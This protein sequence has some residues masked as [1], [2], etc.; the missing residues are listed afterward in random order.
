LN[1]EAQLAAVLAHEIGHVLSLHRERTLQAARRLAELEA[2]MA[3]RL[4][5]QQARETLGTLSVARVRGYSRQHEIEADTWSEKLL[6]GAGYDAA[7]GAEVL[8][9]FVQQEGFW[10]RVGFELWEIPESGGGQGVFATHPSPAERLEL[11]K[12]R[13]GIASLAPSA[14]DAGYMNR[15][16][17]VVFGLSL[18]HGVQRGQRYVHPRRRLAFALPEGW[19]VF[20]EEDRLVTASR[21]HEGLLILRIEDRAASKPVR[22]ALEELAAGRALKAVDN[23]AAGAARGEMARVG[24]AADPESRA[25][26]LAVLDVGAVRLAVVAV[27]FD[28]A[29]EEAMNTHLRALLASVRSLSPSEAQRAAPPRIRI[30]PLQAPGAGAPSGQAFADH[31]Q[32][33]WALLN[34]LEPPTLAAAGRPVKTVR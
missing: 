18:R 9:F 32:A 22:R 20:G 25:V 13:L 8:R 23:L 16:Q 2:K 7:A 19:Y 14:P 26:S 15:L 1:S 17:G 12:K 11:A 34:Q 21:R 28:A 31:V 30:E 27:P 33:R 29:Q 3:E 10:E 24:S 6:K 5:T 4:T